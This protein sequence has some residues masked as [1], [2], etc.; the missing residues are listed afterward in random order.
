MARKVSGLGIGVIIFAAFMILSG[1]VTKPLIEPLYDFDEINASRTKIQF[2]N[3]TTLNISGMSSGEFGSV[4]IN[5]ATSKD[6]KFFC[7]ADLAMIGTYQSGSYNFVVYLD[8]IIVKNY[9]SYIH[10]GGEFYIVA[11]RRLTPH[12][13]ERPSAAP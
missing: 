13:S 7:Y 6:V 5:R 9:S 12:S 4:T 3:S 1:I 11:G 8:N 2:T 10:Q